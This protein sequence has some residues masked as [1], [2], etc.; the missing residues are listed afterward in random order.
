MTTVPGEVGFGTV[1]VGVLCAMLLIMEIMLLI[2]LLIFGEL[3]EVPCPGAG[4][5]TLV[6]VMV[7]VLTPF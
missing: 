1:G 3:A 4:V 6:E 5:A 2:I 7:T